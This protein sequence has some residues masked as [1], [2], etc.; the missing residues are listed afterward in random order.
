VVAVNNVPLEVVQAPLE[1]VD[2]LPL[3]QV[4]K[5]FGVRFYFQEM[6]Q[7]VCLSWN[8]FKAF[9][10]NAR[11]YHFFDP[12]RPPDLVVLLKR[13]IDGAIKLWV[14]IKL[15]VF[16]KQLFQKLRFLS[17]EQKVQMA[18]LDLI[19][20]LDGLK[21]VQV[22][23]LTLLKFDL[24]LRDFAFDLLGRPYGVAQLPIELL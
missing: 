14:I 24:I 21:L 7:L 12:M 13:S 19:D 1:R 9:L 6:L 4:L 15:Q 11:L 8:D 2:G 18:V 20:E 22:V 3:D 10:E 5:D 17:L 23:L 16:R